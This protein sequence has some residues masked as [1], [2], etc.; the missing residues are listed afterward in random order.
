M[1]KTEKSRKPETAKPTRKP[2]DKPTRDTRDSPEPNPNGDSDIPDTSTR[3]EVE[4]IRP[5]LKR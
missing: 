1:A 5:N 4:K 2:K 3:E